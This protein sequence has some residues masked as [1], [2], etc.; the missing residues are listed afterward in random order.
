MAIFISRSSAIPLYLDVVMVTFKCLFGRNVYSM[1]HDD[2]N[3][4]FVQV[5]AQMFLFIGVISSTFLLRE[6][7]LLCCFLSCLTNTPCQGGCSYTQEISLTHLDTH[8]QYIQTRTSTHMQNMK[9]HACIKV[10]HSGRVFLTRGSGQLLSTFDSSLNVKKT[11]SAL[12]S[13]KEILILI[14]IYR[15]YFVYCT[16]LQ[17]CFGFLQCSRLMFEE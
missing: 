12:C 16:L 8:K 6:K 5:E 4:D 11:S 10:R 13:L 2:C 17:T 3:S 15:C 9:P 7:S 1:E 14:S